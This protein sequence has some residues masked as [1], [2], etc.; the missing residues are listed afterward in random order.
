MTIRIRSRVLPLLVP[1][2]LAACAQT[3]VNSVETMGKGEEYYN[4]VVFSDRL[5]EKVRIEEV[6]KQERDGF[7]R[8]QVDI[9]NTAREKQTFLYAFEWFDE[10]GMQVAST[11]SIWTQAT[12]F[13]GEKRSFIATAGSQDA[14]DFRFKVRSK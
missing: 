2:A 7:L 12:I 5:D 10:A 3:P 8:V 1:L 6:I 14:T 4:K 9:V 13:P 11:S